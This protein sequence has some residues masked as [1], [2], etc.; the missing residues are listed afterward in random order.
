MVQSINNDPLVK[1][2]QANGIIQHY[3]VRKNPQQNKVA[4]RMN[5]TLI[6]KLR[7]ML[8]NAGLGKPFWIEAIVYVSHLINWLSS[9]AI[10]GQT[11]MEV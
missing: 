7:C 3:T 4:E 9:T 5:R 8:F 2:Y 11:P 6:E 10:R 1:V